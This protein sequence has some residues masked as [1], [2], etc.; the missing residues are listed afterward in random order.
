MP[1]KTSLDSIARSVQ[2]MVSADESTTRIML[3][4]LQTGYAIGLS[5]AKN[6]S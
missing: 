6:A 1:E 4:L 3:Q 2:E 5:D